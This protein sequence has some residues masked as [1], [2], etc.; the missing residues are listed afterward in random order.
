MLEGMPERGAAAP[1]IC[2]LSLIY[3]PPSLGLA[4]MSTDSCKLLI[5]EKGA[6][7]DKVNH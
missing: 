3:L 5:S 6:Q 2:L 4:V 7:K 1:G